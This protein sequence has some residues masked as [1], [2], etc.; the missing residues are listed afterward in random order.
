LHASFESNQNQYLKIRPSSYNGRLTADH[1]HANYDMI[2]EED[3]D[4]FW[5]EI[6]LVYS[7]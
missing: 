4:F 6:I 7:I 3:D 2:D 1:C 5:E